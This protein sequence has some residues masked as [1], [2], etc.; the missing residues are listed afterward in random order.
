[1]KAKNSYLKRNYT[2]YTYI[3]GK[4]A[5]LRKGLENLGKLERKRTKY[6]EGE[7]QTSRFSRQ[8]LQYQPEFLLMTLQVSEQPHFSQKLYICASKILPHLTNILQIRHRYRT[9]EDLKE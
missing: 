5:S 4:K 1:M 9:D 3:K 6:A 7:N 8:I 2:N